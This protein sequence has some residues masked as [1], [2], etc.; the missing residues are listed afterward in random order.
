MARVAQRGTGLQSELDFE[1]V[2]GRGPRCG[3]RV[4]DPRV[5]QLHALIRWTGTDWEVRDLGSLNGTFVEGDRLESGGSRLLSAGDEVRVAD[6]AAWTFLDVSPP[7]PRI[8]GEDGR[9]LR[10]RTPDLIRIPEAGPA[11][12]WL[13]RT[14]D[15]QWCLEDA[16]GASV[17]TH[18]DTFS[19]AGTNWRFNA[20]VTTSPTERADGAGEG[21]KLVFQVAAN[22]EH[23]VVT[24]RRGDR[25]A[26]LEPRSHGELLL[27]LARAWLEDER[28]SPWERGWVHQDLVCRDLA[29]PRRT[30]NTHVHRARRQLEECGLRD[31]EVVLQRRVSAQQLRLDVVS[32]LIHEP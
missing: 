11:A 20:P 24:V 6:A 22:Q 29:V 1:G 2:I 13:L 32:V 9:L 30:L 3:L 21:F 12:A 26:E 18:G 17:I 16:D 7:L 28:S 23:I 14:P 4:D 15:G 10:A 27:F 5:S 25:T 31:A 19:C 8:E